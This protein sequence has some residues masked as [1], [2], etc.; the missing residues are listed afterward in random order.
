MRFGGFC[1]RFLLAFL[2]SVTWQAWCFPKGQSRQRPRRAWGVWGGLWG[3]FS[4]RPNAAEEPD[5]EALVRGQA[6]ALLR[7]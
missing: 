7:C 1:W 3:S 5:G 2:R 4:D 6:E